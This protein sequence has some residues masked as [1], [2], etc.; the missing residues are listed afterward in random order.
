[1]RTLSG[2]LQLK[3][4]F[5]GEEGI[6]VGGVKQE[7][8]QLIIREIFNPSYG[9]FTLNELTYNFWFFAHSMESGQEYCLVGMIIGVYVVALVD[10]TSLLLSLFFS[11]IFYFPTLFYSILRSFLTRIRFSMTS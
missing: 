7:F 8:F 11:P 10:A 6:D 1:M 9:M 5:I 3:I 4:H 2:S